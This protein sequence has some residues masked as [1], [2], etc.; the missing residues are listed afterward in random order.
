LAKETGLTVPAVYRLA[1]PQH[2]LGRV[3][4]DTLNR[5]CAALRVQPGDLLEWVPGAEKRRS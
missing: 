2:A 1:D 4:V 3:N 5:L